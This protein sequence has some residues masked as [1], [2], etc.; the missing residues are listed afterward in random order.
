VKPITIRIVLTIAVIEKWVVHQ[1]DVSNVFLHGYLTENVYME[2]PPGFIHPSPH[3]VC[4][5]H[6]AV[7]ELKQAPMAWF[8]CLNNQLLEL[9]FI[10]CKFDSSLFLYSKQDVTVFVL[11]YVDD[12]IITS[13]HKNAISQ[14]IADL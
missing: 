11:I 6:N 1:I 8:S 9:N 12:I 14:L 2:L 10:S 3:A 4:K 5:L 13:S 7:Y